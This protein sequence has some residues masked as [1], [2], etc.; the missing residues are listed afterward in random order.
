[1]GSKVLAQCLHF[2]QCVPLVHVHQ[3]VVGT[4]LVLSGTRYSF[5]TEVVV[6]VLQGLQALCE[7]L[8]VKFWGEI[9]VTLLTQ[10]FG[11]DDVEPD[12]IQ[13]FS[14]EALLYASR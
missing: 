12:S 1:M 11:A 10:P 13:L 14:F 9:V 6:D 3:H 5:K 2:S 4:E 8:V 7:V